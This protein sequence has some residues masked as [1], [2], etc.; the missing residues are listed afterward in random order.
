M[1]N[2]TINLPS[3][4]DTGVCFCAL[5]ASRG[6]LDNGN[7]LWRCL[8]NATA[9]IVSGSSGKWFRTQQSES[10]LAGLGNEPQ[11]WAGYPPDLSTTYVLIQG[12]LG[13]LDYVP[14]SQS[15][16]GTLSSADAKCTGRIDTRSSGVYYSQG[17][18]AAMAASAGQTGS[19]SVNGSRRDNVMLFSLLLSMLIATCFAA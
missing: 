2:S 10:S 12:G 11:D 15:N 6:S 16:A 3:F 17:P 4:I 5:E 19:S 13:N 7:Q 9:D 18:A 14:L 8:G 1:S